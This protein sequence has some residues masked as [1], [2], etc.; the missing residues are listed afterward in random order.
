MVSTNIGGGQRG[1]VG[2]YETQAACAWAGRHRIGGL[3]G[4]NIEPP[5]QKNSVFEEKS[6]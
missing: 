4:V 3:K 1:G 5:P 2:I 6:C